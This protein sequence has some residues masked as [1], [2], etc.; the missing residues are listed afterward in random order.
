M[1]DNKLD[2]LFQPLEMSNL[3]L[4]NRFFMAPIGTGFHVNRMTDFLVARAR[5]EVALITT[6]EICVHP[7]GR[8]GIGAELHLE[9]DDDIN[10]VAPMVKAVQNAGAKIIAQLNH[11]G[12]YTFGQLQGQQAVAPSPIASRYTG[13][14][15]RALSTLEADDLV[16]AFA[17]GAV[18]ARK[19]GFDGIEILGC[20]GYL[21]S[22]FLSPLTNRRDDKYGGILFKGRPSS[23]LFFRKQEKEWETISISVLSLMQKTACREAKPWRI[24][25]CCLPI[26]LRQVRIDCTSGRDGTRQHVPCCPCTSLDAPS[27]IWPLLS[28]RS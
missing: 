19:A 17:E 12:R 6:G 28:R 3:R 2:I 23:F 1:H 10:T 18:R 13:E 7:S 16:I 22:Q 21:I 24:R 27:P 9:T 5:G 15:P 20:S 25:F 8:A 11:A 4:K 14:T 26:S